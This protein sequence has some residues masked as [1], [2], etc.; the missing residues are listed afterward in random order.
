MT[1]ERKNVSLGREVGVENLSLHHGTGPATQ[2]APPRFR[3]LSRGA[4][5]GFPPPPRA[6]NIYSLPA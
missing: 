1:N 6:R 4:A 3:V 5:R 2:G